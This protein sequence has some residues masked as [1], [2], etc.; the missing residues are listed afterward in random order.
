ME[1]NILKSVFYKKLVIQY[2]YRKNERWIRHKLY[3]SVN[4]LFDGYGDLGFILC[5]VL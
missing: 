3:N 1:K 2:F 4:Y 5:V